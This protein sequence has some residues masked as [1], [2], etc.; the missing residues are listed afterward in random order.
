MSDFSKDYFEHNYQGD[1]FK[2]NPDYK[3]QSYLNEILRYCS[4]G[5]LLDIGCALGS[6]TYTAQKHFEVIGCDVS[7]YAIE[8]AK[9]RHS[10][11]P[12]LAARVDQIPLKGQFDV[13]TCFD[14]LE[15][16]ADIDHVLRSLKDLMHE[17]TILVISVPVYDSLV[18][19]IVEILDDDETH[20]IKE[21]RY[22]WLDKLHRHHYNILSIKGLFRNLFFGRYYISFFTK[23]FWKVSPAIYLIVQ[24]KPSNS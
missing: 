11:I 18:G 3:L 8:E 9:K 15:H 10:D 21:S 20:L 2:R 7:Q 12:F 4:R 19:K 23:I 1:Y 24:M 6:F 5:R 17:N 22:F 13:I 14:V 16:V